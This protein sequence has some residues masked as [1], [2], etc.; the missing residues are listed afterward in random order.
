MCE[1]LG[2]SL[3]SARKL[4]L[5]ASL[6][7]V[8]MPIISA[9]VAVVLVLSIIAA[10]VTRTGPGTVAPNIFSG[11]LLAFLIAVTAVGVA[12]LVL[13]LLAMY[14]LSHY[15]NEPAIFN[16]VFY[17]FILSL[18]SGIILLVLQFTVIASLLPPLPQTGTPTTVFPFA[19]FI[20]VYLAVL[21]V[22]LV[23]GIVNAVLY[24][25]AFNKLAE[26]SGVDNFKTAGL[27]Y[28]IGVLLTIVL[29]GG[30]LVWI[31]W[32]FAAMGFNKLK[33]APVAAQSVSYPP[34]PPLFS[35]VAQT[36]RCPNCGTE[37]NSD[38]LFCRTCGNKLQ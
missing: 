34:P 5:T 28:L 37:N 35:S 23:F 31:A 8:L 30:I 22:S 19:Q 33:A 1:V 17:A 12:S 13:F 38:A 6:M 10:A 18:F 29:I 14:R 11:G 25:R 24:M 3:E 16:N 2:M 26:K 27:L 20:I 32:I 36:K 15:Y 9:V 7:Y 21:G 4:G